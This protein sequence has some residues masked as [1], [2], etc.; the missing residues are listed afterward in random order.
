MTVRTFMRRTG[1]P[2]RRQGGRT[3][4]LRRWQTRP[5]SAWR[6]PNRVV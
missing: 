5:R 2:V 4:F 3:P 1:I 6:P